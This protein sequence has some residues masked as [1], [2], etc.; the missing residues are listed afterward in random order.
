MLAFDA[1]RK[2]ICNV[3]PPRSST[4]IRIAV[5]MRFS[6]GRR[7]W[8]RSASWYVEGKNTDC[9]SA[10]CTHEQ[11]E[12]TLRDTTM[13][14]AFVYLPRVHTSKTHRAQQDRDPI[15]VKCHHFR[16]HTLQGQ[17]PATVQ[18]QHQPRP[19]STRGRARVPR[20]A[21]CQ[22]RT[23]ASQSQAQRESRYPR[24][25][26]AWSESE[27]FSQEQRRVAF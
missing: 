9:N 16:H 13:I 27:M 3:V 25:V 24:S 26:H 15:R 6:P 12:Q 8:V 19:R 17:T 14:Q 1:S 18:E 11:S 4:N 10:L 21:S 7:R 2:G 22:L 5:Q 20:E 23:P